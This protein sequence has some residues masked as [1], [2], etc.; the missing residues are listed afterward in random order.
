MPDLAPSAA[1]S[2][3]S[4]RWRRFINQGSD[5]VAPLL[6]LLPKALKLYFVGSWDFDGFGGISQSQGIRY[7]FLGI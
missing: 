1:L 3:R 4:G 7:L 2:F 5:F 6:D